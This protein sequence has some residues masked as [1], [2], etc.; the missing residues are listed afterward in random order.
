MTAIGFLRTLS[1]YVTRFEN[2]RVESSLIVT[3]VFRVVSRAATQK[4]MPPLIRT[5]T[6][7][8]AALHI[9]LVVMLTTFKHQFAF[10][11]VSVTSIVPARD[12]GIKRGQRI[13]CRGRHSKAL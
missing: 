5:I 7:H 2:I 1:H 12:A 8:K 6:I 9:L 4:D 3:I 13:R 11:H 10:S